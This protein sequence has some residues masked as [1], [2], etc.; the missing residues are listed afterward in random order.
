MNLYMI[1]ITSGR[2]ILKI[3]NLNNRERDKCKN[4]QRFCILLLHQPINDCSIQFWYK[5]ISNFNIN[6]SIVVG[7]TLY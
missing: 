1:L 6:F 7:Y 4:F 2:N 3:G 5:V